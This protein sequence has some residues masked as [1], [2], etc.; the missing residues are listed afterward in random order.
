[1]HPQCPRRG[2][3]ASVNPHPDHHYSRQYV[4]QH[5][6]N[7]LVDGNQA[8]ERQPAANVRS[9]QQITQHEQPPARMTR[10]TPRLRLCSQHTDVR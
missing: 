5:P 7:A 6:N 2:S 10:P 3:C 8:S 9:D 4:H 1:M